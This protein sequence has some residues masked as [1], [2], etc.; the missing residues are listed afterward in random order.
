MPADKMSWLLQGHTPALP[1][2]HS[3]SGDASCFDNLFLK[4]KKKDNLTNS[5]EF[6]THTSL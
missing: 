5:N 6:M 2:G 3:I 1:G 4:E